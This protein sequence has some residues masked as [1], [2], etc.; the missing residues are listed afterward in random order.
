MATHPGDGTQEDALKRIPLAVVAFTGLTYVP[1]FGMCTQVE[2][3]LTR[4]VGGVTR[5]F[6]QVWLYPA[7]R[8]IEID[9][10][11]YPLE[12]VA[13]WKRAKMALGKKPKPADI[14]HR[15]GKLVSRTETP[16]E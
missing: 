11:E 2:T 6:P 8:V 9:G 14:S 3:G 4:I 7:L 5:A 10:C 12:R 1:E 13:Y 15:I 16:S